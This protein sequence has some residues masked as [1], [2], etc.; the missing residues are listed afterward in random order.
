M[1]LRSIEFF[2]RTVKSVLT[3]VQYRKVAHVRIVCF[4]LETRKHAEDLCPQDV[5]LG[6]DMLRRGEGGVSA[7][8]IW[9]SEDQ[10]CSFY[11]DFTIQAAARHLELADVVVGYSST[12]FDVPVV[13][14]L[15]GRR[16]VLR[17]HVDL[18]AEIAHVGAERGLIGTKGDCTLDRVCKRNI[19]RGKI[20]HGSHAKELAAKAR[21]AQLFNYCADDVRL[22]RDLFLYVCEHGG[23]RVMTTYVTLDIPEWLRKAGLES[24]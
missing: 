24:Q 1:I 18:Y 12:A 17:Y 22:T 19:G 20:N 4:D 2:V 23:L 10:W 21:W 14:G 15:I 11:D 6:W 7:L 16:L 5:D 3:E 13:E 8:A 9:D